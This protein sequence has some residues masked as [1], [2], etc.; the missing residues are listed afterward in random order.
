MDHLSP[1]AYLAAGIALAV[2]LFLGARA[3]LKQKAR[4]K[5][6]VEM[7]GRV[8]RL[9]QRIYDQMKNGKVLDEIELSRR[10]EQLKSYE[11]ANR[12]LFF[13]DDAQTIREFLVAT[14]N[15]HALILASRQHSSL[16]DDFSDTRAFPEMSVEAGGEFDSAATRLSA[17]KERFFGIAR[18]HG[19]KPKELVPAD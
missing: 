12:K 3:L 6:T 19:V 7:Y 18:K 8:S 9:L 15:L 17:L 5:K 2:A 10:V 1:L 16:I 4:K 14:S 11:A 13:R